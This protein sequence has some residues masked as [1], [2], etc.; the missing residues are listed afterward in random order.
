MYGTCLKK[1]INWTVPVRRKYPG[2]RIV[3]RKIDSKSA[4][5]RCNLSAATAIQCCTQLLALA[6]IL[7]YL[8]LTFGGCPC[9]N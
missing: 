7:L 9:P 1:L 3:A 6:L 4:F 5:K 2:R 8:R